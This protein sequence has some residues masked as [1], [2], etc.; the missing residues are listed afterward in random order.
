[1]SGTVNGK[2]RNPMTQPPSPSLTDRISN[3]AFRALMS[4]ARML[5]YEKRIPMMGW[6]VSRL[7]APVTGWRNRIRENLRLT[8]PDL[9]AQEVERLV[10]A[11]PDRVGR[12][13]AETYSGHEFIR[14]MQ[15]SPVEGPGLA[16][17]ETAKAEG[18][19][20][21]IAGAHFG[22]YDA[23]RATLTSRGF[24][25]GG[26]YRPMGNQLFN[27][28]YV[29]A[30]KA[31]SLPL[32][33]RG[34]EMREMLKF[35]KSG[36]MVALAFDQH[37]SSAPVLSFFGLPARTA[38]SAAEMALRLDADLIPVYAIRQPDGL[39]FRVLVDAP[40]AHSDALTMT[41]TLNDQLEVMIRAHMDQWL[42]IHRRWKEYK[43]EQP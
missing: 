12:S 7:V 37:F 14:R 41:Q 33:A 30:I 11:V 27:D 5:P 42:W 1:M 15:E 13:I 40:I 31:I 17:L 43:P 32:F 36:G 28:H 24:P 9:P 8:C 25:I 3:T 29:K 38:I 34:L 23:W 16:A 19:P 18:R 35:L 21:I 20:V 22:N 4:F 10:Y 2:L 39:S 26:V 6:V